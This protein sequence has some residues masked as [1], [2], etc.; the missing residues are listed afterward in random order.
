MKQETSV[1]SGSSDPSCLGLITYAGTAKPQFNSLSA[2]L[3]LLDDTGPSF[4]PIPLG[5]TLSGAT[6]H[7]HSLLFQK[8]EGTYYVVLW[9]G[10]SLWDLSTKTVVTPAPQTVTIKAQRPQ[11]RATLS[12]FSMTT[13]A[14]QQTRPSFNGSVSVSV[15]GMPVVVQLP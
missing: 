3:Q 15:T 4:T 6:S 1:V 7:V 9:L 2:L 8:S 12:T 11:G 13:G 10:V 5:L 14:L